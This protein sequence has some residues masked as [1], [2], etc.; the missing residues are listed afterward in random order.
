MPFDFEKLPLKDAYLIY[1]KKFLD[2]RGFFSELFREDFF[3]EKGIN[4]Q[5][6]QINLSLSKKG[7]VRGLHFQRKPFTQAKL[8]YCI[9]GKI[10]DVIVDLRPDSPTFKKWYGT[11]LSPDKLNALFVPRGFAHGFAALEER[12]QVLYA[13]DNT[14]SKHHDGGI[15]WNDPDLGIEWPFKKPILS[16]KDKKLPF[17]KDI[18]ADL[19]NYW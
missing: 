2:N 15:R 13:V 17:L 7:V 10:Y 5:P 14:Y 8:V 12:S 3:A 19:Q 16:E 9:A 11:V 18:E 6:V 4:F 1:A